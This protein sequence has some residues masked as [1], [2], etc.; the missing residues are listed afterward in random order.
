[1]LM[2]ICLS[3][4]QKRGKMMY[5]KMFSKKYPG[6][7]NDYDKSN[8]EL[9]IRG[10]SSLPAKLKSAI[11]NSTKDTPVIRQKLAQVL[12]DF[13]CEKINIPTVKVLVSESSRP[14]RTNYAGS[15][16]SQTLGQYK[17]AY[18]INA[19]PISIKIWNLTAVRKQ[20]IS[21]KMFLGTLE[22]ELIH[23]YDIFKLGM[24]K[25]PHTAGF[26]RRI[27]LLDKMFDV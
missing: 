9:R 23:H 15:V 6:G 25:S 2:K 7:N 20:R 1:M 21:N 5:K 10:V 13:V 22:H 18:N 19:Y 12:V 17:Y 11:V 16:K 14:H 8:S 27:E 24:A 26:Y 3:T 4:T